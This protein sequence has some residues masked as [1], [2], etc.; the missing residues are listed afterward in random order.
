MRFYRRLRPFKAISFDLDDTLYDNQPVIEQAEREFLQYLTVLAPKSKALGP[1]FWHQHRHQCLADNPDL[2]HDVSA[3]RIACIE[4]GMTSLGYQDAKARANQAF[5]HFLSHRNQVQVADSVKS[6][7]ARLAK[8]YPLVAISNG[9][10]SIDKIGLKEYFSHCFFAGNGNLQ[11][12]ARHMFH[13][14]CEVLAIE[15]KQLLH[16]GDCT[17]ADIYGALGAGCQTIWVNNPRF[18]I[19]KKPLKLLPS[20]EFDSVEQLQIFVR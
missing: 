15:P 11:K 17:H 19:Q 10:V 3:L 12:P 13:Q 9:N 6:L 2:S 20:A 16:I 4:L 1:D 18:A 8:T 14:T 5:A 7:L